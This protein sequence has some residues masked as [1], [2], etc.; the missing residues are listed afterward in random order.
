MIDPK[1]LRRLMGQFASGVTIITTRDVEGRPYGLTANAFT[2]LS[3]DPPL[4]LFSLDRRSRSLPLW[5]RA[6]GYAINVLAENQRDLSNRFAWALTKS[7]EGLRFTPGIAGA[8]V[9]SG[10][11]AVFE[12]TPWAR[13]DGGDHLLFIAEVEH[14]TVSADRAPLVFSK[15]HY[16]SL[17]PT[18]LVAPLW[19]L[20]IHY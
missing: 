6:E 8:P 9:L 13:H 15:G 12:C 14:F 5:E 2:S 20:D 16:A 1:E 10:V 4:I 17:Q 3:L 18:E 7:G 19:P 11:A